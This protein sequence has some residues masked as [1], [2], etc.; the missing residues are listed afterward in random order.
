MRRRV[1][2]QDGCCA[3]V[4]RADAQSPPLAA[5]AGSRR[6]GRRGRL[7]VAGRQRAPTPTTGPG[8]DHF[9]GVRFFNP[10]R[11]AAEGTW[12]FLKWQLSDRGS[13]GRSSFPEPLPADR[14]PAQLRRRRGCAS[15][16]VGHASFL[17]QTRGRNLLIDP[18]WAERA[19]PFSFAGP[20]RV[21]PPGIAFDDL[22]TIDAVL[23]THNHYD[24]MDVGT[25]RRGCGSA[26]ARA[27]SRRSATTRSCSSACR[28]SR[29]RAVDWGDS[30]DLGDGLSV[31]ARA[32]AA[33]VG[34]RHRRPH[35]RA[36]GE[37]RPA[38]PAA[39]R[40]IAS[41]TAASATARPSPRARAPSGPRAG[42]AADRRLRAALVHAQQ[43]HE[44]RRS[45]G[46]AAAV[47]RARWRSATIGA[48]FS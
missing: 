36:V 40:S 38:A 29:P 19:S 26:S 4:S 33:L 37:L 23:V 15:R 2:P 35:A 47:R 32:D 7:G 42:A 5:D 14:P 22:P 1:S 11:H 43:P 48:R 24:H 34:A 18:V 6:G 21:N 30:V 3:D 28:A 9:D 31:H 16:Y 8:S 20:K 45:R 46:G 25:H 10:E 12:R 13:R 17:I 39:R 44:P 41:A 27:S